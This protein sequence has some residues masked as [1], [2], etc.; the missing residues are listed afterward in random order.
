M[1]ISLTTNRPH[2]HPP[3]SFKCFQLISDQLIFSDKRE[4]DLKCQWFPRPP[5]RI[6]GSLTLRPHEKWHRQ[7]GNMAHPTHLLLC[8]IGIPRSVVVTSWLA[9]ICLHTRRIGWSNPLDFGAMNVDQNQAWFL[10][11]WKNMSHLSFGGCMSI[12]LARVNHRWKIIVAVRGY[13]V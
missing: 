4:Q 3:H 9:D 6:N 10:A 8:Y 12:W 7:R 2:S 13:R 11:T 5:Q 1:I